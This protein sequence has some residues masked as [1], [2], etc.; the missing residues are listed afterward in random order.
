M[1][2][3]TALFVLAMFGVGYFV[4][5]V[6]GDAHATLAKGALWRFYATVQKDMH[7]LPRGPFEQSHTVRLVRSDNV[8][9]WSQEGDA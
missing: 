4:G 5:R 8:F 9:D 7:E 2:W 3:T 6:N 1:D